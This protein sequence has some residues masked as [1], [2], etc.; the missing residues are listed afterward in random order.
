LSTI[1][2]LKDSENKLLSRRELTVVFRGGSGLITR[3]AAAEAISSRMGVQ[4]DKIS[5]VSLQGK[6]G[7]RD[8]VGKVYIYTSAGEMKKQLPVF[9]SIRAL[10]KAERK[11]ARDALKPKPAVP[12]ADAKKK[13]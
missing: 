10:P 1:E 11:A 8:L 3:P 13:S 9:L 6:F 2:I 12:G 5:V 4:K 7:L